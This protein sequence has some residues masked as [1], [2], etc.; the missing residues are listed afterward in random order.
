MITAGD[1]VRALNRHYIKPSDEMPGGVF[2]TEVALGNRRIDALY[3]GFWRSRGQHMIGHEIKVSR[4]DWLK[5]LDTPAKA[6]V[7]E[8]NCHSWYVVAPSTDIVKPEELPHGWGLLVP[9]K[10]KTRMTTVVRAQLHPERVPSWPSMNAVIQKS[11]TLR[12]HS[13]GE[14]KRD[15]NHEVQKR[16]EQEVQK[17]LNDD[18]RTKRLTERA[19]KAERLVAEISE[20]IGMEVDNERSYWSS[21]AV[22]VE[23]LAGG[24]AK[25][26]QLERNANL[27]ITKRTDELKQM[28]KKLSEILDLLPA[29]SADDPR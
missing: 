20:A 25:Y 10:S 4:S 18:Y 19:E 28:H 17:R 22:S 29:G 6:E 14:V 7:W 3:V 21:G 13:V 8:Q 27:A 5:E 2:L 12:A 24:F 23:E 1:L 16:L 26:L 11:D 9:G 15:I